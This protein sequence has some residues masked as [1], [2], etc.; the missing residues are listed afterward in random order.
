MP[1]VEWSKDNMRYVMCFFSLIG[2]VIGGVIYLWSR[3][4]DYL[5]MS[6]VFDTAII[7]LLPLILTGGIHMDGFMDTTDALCSYQPREKK[8]EI[9][10]DPNSGAFAVIGCVGYYLLTYAVWYDVTQTEL[11]ILAIGF[12]LSRALSG[13]AVVTFPLAKNSGLAATFSNEAKKRLTRNVMI[14]F[15]ILCAIGMLLLNRKLGVIGLIA[16]FIA[17]LY[18]YRISVKEFGGITGDLAGYF[19]QLCELIV[20]AS[21]I[22]GGKVCG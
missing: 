12:I 8:L 11:T 13:L 20:A 16:A 7:V 22:I 17:F 3:I 14:V 19:L 9:L 21:V 1:K 2:A 5:S 4:A 10:K 18:Y 6:R 15:I